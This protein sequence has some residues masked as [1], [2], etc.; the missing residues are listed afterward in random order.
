MW[1]ARFLSC[2]RPKVARGPNIACYL[3]TQ[4]LVAAIINCHHLLSGLPNIALLDKLRQRTASETN[5]VSCED[6]SQSNWKRCLCPSESSPTRV[7]LATSEYP[8]LA[9][10]TT[11]RSSHGAGGIIQ[12]PL[13]EIQV[14]C[15]HLLVSSS[16]FKVIMLIRHSP[17]WSSWENRAVCVHGLAPPI[18][19]FCD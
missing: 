10:Q 9:S 12:Q 6:P 15:P 18:W 5:P 13:E 1:R 4:R 14:C 8:K 16:T 7:S 11:T 19:R 2:P 3:L 17:G